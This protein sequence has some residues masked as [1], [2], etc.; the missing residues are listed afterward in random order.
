MRAA[1]RSAL[2]GASSVISRPVKSNRARAP[3]WVEYLVRPPW[4]DE[5]D[6]VA[7]L[8]ATRSAASLATRVE[9]P[10]PFD[11]AAALPA[12]SV[13]VARK[14]QLRTLPMLKNTGWRLG[15]MPVTAAHDVPASM[16][17]S[18]CWSRISVAASV[19]VQRITTGMPL[20]AAVPPVGMC[21]VGADETTG[22]VTSPA[23][24]ALEAID[25]VVA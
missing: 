6:A 5:P 12:Q 4:L 2:L 16:L 10:P 3:A 9:K 11:V 17:N 14:R 21:A 19:A 18:R 25:S 22:G 7:H 8:P 23:G 15:Q 20:A 24:S 1:P 13:G